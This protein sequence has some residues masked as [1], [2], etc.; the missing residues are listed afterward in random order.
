MPGSR[1]GIKT[2]DNS[3]DAFKD[4]VLIWFSEDKVAIIKLKD[5]I[6]DNYQR[7]VFNE[8]D[9][10]TLQRALG[11]KNPT[12]EGYDQSNTKWRICFTSEKYLCSTE[13]E[14]LKILF[15]G[16][17]EIEKIKKEFSN[18][19]EYCKSGTKE[20]NCKRYSS[21]LKSISD[22]AKELTDGLSS[23][24]FNGDDP[25]WDTYSNFV[26][27]CAD[28]ERMSIKLNRVNCD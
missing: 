6:F 3:Y 19:L 16:I 22:R 2:G 21:D 10:N 8:V 26:Q 15:D 9:K 25:Y 24:S 13:T 7:I 17:N 18:I 4:Y 28:I 11:G 12:F 23:K 27:T 14:P 20:D 5:D 1:L